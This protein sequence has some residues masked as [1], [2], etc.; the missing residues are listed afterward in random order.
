[1]YIFGTAVA[2]NVLRTINL[3]DCKYAQPSP[4]RIA[5]RWAALNA[6]TPLRQTCHNQSPNVSCPAT[7]RRHSKQHAHAHMHT[8]K[9]ALRMPDS[10]SILA[11]GPSQKVE[12]CPCPI[13][14][15]LT[16]TLVPVDRCADYTPKTAKPFYNYATHPGVNSIRAVL[17]LLFT[18]PPVM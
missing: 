2:R 9:T 18:A 4:R 5:F 1:M 6:L 8:Q 3:M 14:Q 15:L 17:F 7:H 16:L 13:P 12:N 10:H 11:V